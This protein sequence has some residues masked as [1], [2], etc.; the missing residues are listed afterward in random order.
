[1]KR[2]GKAPGAKG[3]F[4]RKIF[5]D[6]RGRV[7]WQAPPTALAR[8]SGLPSVS[9]VALDHPGDPFRVLVSTMISLRTKDEV[10]YAAAGRLFAKAS[11][12]A[13]VAALPEKEIEKLI[14]PA[15]FYKTKAVHIREA[16]RRIEAECLG[17]V[18]A[19]RELLMGLPGVG[20]KTANLV[21]NLGFGI[22]A[23]CVDTHVHRI[24]NRAGWVETKTPEETEYALCEIMPRRFWIPLNELLVKYGQTVCTPA[25]PHCGSCPLADGRCARRGVTR[26][27]G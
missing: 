20:R 4:W 1:M 27:R 13:E 11:S 18:P 15:G 17:K 6:L 26:T 14:Y 16:S 3:A 25:S 12:P 7:G 23:I 8:I 2:V 24:S 22:D 10:T 19:D 5:A 21:L 9:Q